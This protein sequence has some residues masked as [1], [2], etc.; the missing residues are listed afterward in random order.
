MTDQEL[1]EYCQPIPSQPTEPPDLRL[2]CYTSPYGNHGYI[3]WLM[4]T[5]T[6]LQLIN[7]SRFYSERTKPRADAAKIALEIHKL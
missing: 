7:S 2:V 6:L 5:E 1:I 3:D 4:K